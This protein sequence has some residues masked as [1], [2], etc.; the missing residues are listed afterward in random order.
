MKRD[1]F[2]RELIDALDPRALFEPPRIFLNI[3]RS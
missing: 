1:H 3:H 2:E